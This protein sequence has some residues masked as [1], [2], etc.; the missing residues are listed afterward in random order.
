M[1]LSQHSKPVWGDIVKDDLPPQ[2]KT[3][4]LEELLH[5]AE[6]LQDACDMRAAK[7]ASV[8]AASFTLGTLLMSGSVGAT[9][10]F[11]PA[12]G[13][14]VAIIAGATIFGLIFLLSEYV[15]RSVLRQQRRDRRALREVVFIL[16]EVEP[17]LAEEQRWST[18]ERVNFR[19]RISRFEI[20]RPAE[21]LSQTI[22]EV[23]RGGF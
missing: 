10:L 22:E 19:L 5:Y 20:G 8:R 23:R 15:V 6:A 12:E 21:T 1:N 14:V 7:I 18:L 11:G 4:E 3:A 9:W 13:I 2:S 17:S 16:R